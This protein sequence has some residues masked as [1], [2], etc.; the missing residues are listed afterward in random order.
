MGLFVHGVFQGMV[1]VDEG[2]ASRGARCEIFVRV[3][4]V[5]SV[6]VLCDPLGGM[7]GDVVD[8]MLRSSQ[9]L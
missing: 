1:D 8:D 2:E 6:E 7:F 9:V 4:F 5:V 3:R